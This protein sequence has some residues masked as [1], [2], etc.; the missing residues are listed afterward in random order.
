MRL[1]DACNIRHAAVAY[2]Q[3]VTVEDLV[4]GV[5]T[6]KMFIYTVKESFCYIRYDVLT[7]WRIEPNNLSWPIFPSA[8]AAIVV[9]QL[10]A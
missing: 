4:Q 5:V 9:L 7:E 8:R 2:F 1:Y 10:V 3:G 6:S